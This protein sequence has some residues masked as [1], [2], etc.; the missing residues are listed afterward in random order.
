MLLPSFLT[1][2]NANRIM[3]TFKGNRVA[4]IQKICALETIAEMAKYLFDKE[5]DRDRLPS[6]DSSI[7]PTD[8]QMK[9]SRKEETS[10]KNG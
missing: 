3:V 8:D 9:N 6:L 2:D 1:Q 10:L 4:V 7:W 5:E